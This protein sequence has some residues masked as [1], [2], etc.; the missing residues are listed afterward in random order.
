MTG[1]PSRNVLAEITGSSDILREAGDHLD[2]HLRR[3]ILAQA[4]LLADDPA[5]RG[6]SNRL[7]VR[8]RS[9][10]EVLFT[11]GELT[12]EVGDD[13]LEVTL[14]GFLADQHVKA[15]SERLRDRFHNTL[16]IAVSCAQKWPQPNGR[17]TR[18]EIM[19]TGGGHALPMVRAL[20]EHPSIPWT[21]LAP[22]PD[23]AQR[24]EDIDFHKVRRQ[25]A[26][27]IGGAV[28]DLPTQTAPLRSSS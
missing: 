14:E 19:L 7:R 6:V 20:Y 18:V 27:A 25:L 1:L 17:Q 12:V 11:D 5:A 23:L 10:K 24:P 9:N 13:L 26:V 15:F 22:A 3:H 21:Y 28:R 4:G 2:M 8:A 16:S